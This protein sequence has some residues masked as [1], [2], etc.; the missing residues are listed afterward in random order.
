MPARN[1]T[2]K[3]DLRSYYQRR[4]EVLAKP[5]IDLAGDLLSEE[6][7]RQGQEFEDYIERRLNDGAK[8]IP[9]KRQPC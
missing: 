2:E 4:V 9:R 3:T 7:V 8:F 5:L 6:S 1:T